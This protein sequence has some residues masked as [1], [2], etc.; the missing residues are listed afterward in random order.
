MGA[1]KATGTP[2]F[3]EHFETVLRQLDALKAYLERLLLVGRPTRLKPD[4]VPVAALLRRAMDHARESRGV[5]DLPLTLDLDADQAGTA[6]WDAEA[7]LAAVAAVVD[8][9]LDSRQPPPPTRLSARSKGDLVVIEVIDEG[10]GIAPELLPLLEIPMAA[11]RAG[12]TGL[13]L[14]IA[15]KLIHAHGGD[16]DI[17]SSAAGTRVR[18]TLPREAPHV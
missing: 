4:E 13:G 1:R 6:R 5:G 8:N 9:A 11:R 14:A 17:E 7:V 18:F 10:P 15:R 3:K 12:S 2:E 16:L